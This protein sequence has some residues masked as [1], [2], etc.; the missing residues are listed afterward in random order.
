MKACELYDSL[1]RICHIWQECCGTMKDIENEVRLL[2][3]EL[4]DGVASRWL[5]SWLISEYYGDSSAKYDALAAFT[6][7]VGAMEL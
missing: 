6:A 5:S 1:C 7:G 3:D 2:V 4:P